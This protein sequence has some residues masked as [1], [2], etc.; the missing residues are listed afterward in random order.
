MLLGIGGV[1]FVVGLA[2]GAF[3]ALKVAFIFWAA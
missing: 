2:M 1:F 3:S